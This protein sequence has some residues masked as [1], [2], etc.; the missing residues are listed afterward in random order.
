MP[1]TEFIRKLNPP[2]PPD[3]IHA[4]GKLSYRNFLTVCLVVNKPELFDDNWIYV[5]DPDVNV[6]RIQN[7]KNWSPYM[8]P[9]P[10]MTSLGLEYFCNEGDEVWC[11][12]D[13]IIE[14]G[15]REIEKIGLAKAGMSLMG[16]F[17]G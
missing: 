5:H 9:D 2:P 16:C 13:R 1:I 7:F 6:G 8:V 4:A 3:V 11:M 17:P 12:P 10:S 15:K 14:L